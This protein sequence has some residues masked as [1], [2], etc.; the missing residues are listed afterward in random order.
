MGQVSQKQAWLLSTRRQS[1]PSLSPVCRKKY[2]R[3]AK[4]TMLDTRKTCPD[5]SIHMYVGSLRVGLEMPLS[6]GLRFYST[7]LAKE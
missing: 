4:Q 6:K 7:I 1:P 2:V 3:I 5:Q